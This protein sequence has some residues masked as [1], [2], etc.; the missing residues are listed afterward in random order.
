MIRP[1]QRR[2]LRRPPI[3]QPSRLRKYSGEHL[4]YEI[5]MFFAAVRCRSLSVAAPGVGVGWFLRNAC[6]EAFANHLRNLVA[7][8]YPDVYPVR[9]HDVAAHHFLAGPSPYASWRRA[10]P[11]LSAALRKAKARADKELAHLTSKRIAGVRPAKAW[12]IIPL[13]QEVRSVLRVF[14]AEADPNRLG[15]SVAAAIPQGPL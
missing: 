1:K 2:Q 4:V 9:A 13:A 12:A 8:L 10:R 11:P 5:G 14:V 6:I 3:S 7:F 15:N